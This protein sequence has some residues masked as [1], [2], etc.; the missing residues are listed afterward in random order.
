MKAYQGQTR[1][2]G[3]EKEEKRE[4]RERRDYVLLVFWLRASYCHTLPD[5]DHPDRRLVWFGMLLLVQCQGLVGSGVRV[6]G[7][8]DVMAQ[9]ESFKGGQPRP[10]FLFCVPLWG[11]VSLFR[12]EDPGLVRLLPIQY[13]TH[14]SSYRVQDTP[15][16]V[17]RAE[18]KT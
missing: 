2:E 17:P 16:R 10:C 1:M 4:G 7:W 5:K 9:S 18:Y 11:I 14:V 15:Y 12:H 6:K 13:D 3:M 8:S